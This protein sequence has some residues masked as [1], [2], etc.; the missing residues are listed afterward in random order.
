MMEDRIDTLEGR[1]T[2]LETANKLLRAGAVHGHIEWDGAC[3]PLTCGCCGGRAEK[4][5]DIEH[6]ADCPVPASLKPYDLDNPVESDFDE[7]AGTLAKVDI[8]QFSTQYLFER[9][10]GKSIGPKELQT[11]EQHS[12]ILLQLIARGIADYAGMDTATEEM[13][14]DGVMPAGWTIYDVKPL[15]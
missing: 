3:Y 2:E 11:L 9:E 8:D 13:I 4:A 5:E 10:S 12:A 15:P 1:V 6:N 14:A 7:G